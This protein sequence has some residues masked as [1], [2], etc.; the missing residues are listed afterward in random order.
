MEQGGEERRRLWDCSD[1]VIGALIEVHRHLGAGLLE[2]AYESSACHELTLR[3]F[4]AYPLAC[5]SISTCP[6]SGKAC[7]AS[8][9]LRPPLL[10]LI[11]HRI[12]PAAL[13]PRNN[14][15]AMAR[16]SRP[17]PMVVAPG[18]PPDDLPV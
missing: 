1:R 10:L 9:C 7:V 6:S 11:I 12:L 3:G 16:S 8:G 4:R 17:R 5:W 2:S 18:G 13:S 14:A 15:V